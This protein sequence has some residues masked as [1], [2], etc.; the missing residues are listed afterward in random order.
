M[1]DHYEVVGSPD[2]LIPCT[3]R[4]DS[5]TDEIKSFSFYGTS[6]YTAIEDIGNLSD[7]ELKTAV[8][9]MLGDLADFSEYN[10]FSVRRPP[11]SVGYNTDIKLSWQVRRELPCSI[12]VD[13]VVSEDGLIKSFSKANSCP[14]DLSK[15][16]LTEEERN[17]LIEK[18]VCKEMGIKKLGNVTYKILSETLTCRKEKN[19]LSYTVEIM[20]EQGFSHVIVM[21]IA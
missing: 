9:D 6:P 11:D 12:G 21:T 3:I 2:D 14:D 17:K 7:D 10:S 18:G 20:D 8:E 4:L 5:E 15:S 16:F 13:V 1:Y 19:A